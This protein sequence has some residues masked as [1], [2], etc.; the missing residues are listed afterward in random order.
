MGICKK[1]FKY[2]GGVEKTSINISDLSSDIYVVTVFN[3]K[4]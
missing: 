4:E 2:S 3:G 1:Q